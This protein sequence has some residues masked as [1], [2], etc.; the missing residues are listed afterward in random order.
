MEVS[1]RVAIACRRL[2]WGLS[3]LGDLATHYAIL[4][5]LSFRYP[6]RMVGTNPRVS[7][8]V[9][10]GRT[11]SGGLARCGRMAWRCGRSRAFSRTRR[12]G[13]PNAN[14][15]FRRFTVGNQKR[16]GVAQVISSQ[17]L[18]R[19]Q[20]DNWPV[21][22]PNFWTAL[23]LQRQSLRWAVCRGRGGE[24]GGLCVE[25]FLFLGCFNPR[26]ILCLCAS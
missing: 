19:N 24:R 5:H 21:L 6:Q 10:R 17:G 12:G 25:G 1:L 3:D 13:G 11:F 23:F 14:R 16:E 2:N 18:D 9:F 22:V 4:D 15:G 20:A 26:A 8:R 7:L